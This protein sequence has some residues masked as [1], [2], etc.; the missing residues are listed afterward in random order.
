VTGRLTG[1]T[2]RLGR[3]GRV[4]AGGGKDREAGRSR[5]GQGQG[6]GEEQAGARTGR[7]G[8]AGG[9]KSR[10]EQEAPARLYGPRVRRAVPARRRRLWGDWRGCDGCG[11]LCA[12]GGGREKRPELLARRGAWRTGI[13]HQSACRHWCRNTGASTRSGLP[14]FQ[15]IASRPFS[16]IPGLGHVWY[17]LDVLEWLAD[18]AVAAAAG[19]AEPTAIDPAAL[20]ARIMGMMARL[21]RTTS[22]MAYVQVSRLLHASPT[23]RRRRV[24]CELLSV[25]GPHDQYQSIN[26]SFQV[27]NLSHALK[28]GF[29]FQL[30]GNIDVLMPRNMP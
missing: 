28:C 24:I 16:G 15:R 23:R 6:G 30:P 22:S 14:R 17:Q 25:F 11:G 7:Q 20:S 4:R 5:R 21:M 8:G 2:G 12:W 3:A 10:R 19:S 1:R 9:G 13:G 18:G 29:H 26:P 27:L